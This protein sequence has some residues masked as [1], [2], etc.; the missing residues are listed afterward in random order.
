M[1][2]C[3]LKCR[4]S[5][6]SDPLELALWAV[7]GFLTL[8]LGSKLRSSAVSVLLTKLPLQVVLVGTIETLLRTCFSNLHCPTPWI[9][10]M[11]QNTHSHTI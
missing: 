1:C 7:E 3:T 2:V 5:E 6:A 9:L 11:I 10:F 4:P 8:V